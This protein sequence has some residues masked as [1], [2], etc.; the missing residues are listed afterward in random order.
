MVQIEIKTLNS[1]MSHFNELTEE[2][3]KE[4]GIR[5]SFK[6]RCIFDVSRKG[7]T[8]T[9]VFDADAEYRED[10]SKEFSKVS[11]QEQGFFPIPSDMMIIFTKLALSDERVQKEIV[12]YF[13]EMPDLSAIETPVMA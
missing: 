9:F 13:G 3:K 8:G 6:A 2:Q 7:L 10:E 11:S 5:K 1:V 4:L 12:S